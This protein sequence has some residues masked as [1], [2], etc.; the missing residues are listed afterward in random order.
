MLGVFCADLIFFTQVR[1]AGAT[2]GAFY[3]TKHGGGTVDSIPFVGVDRSVNPDWGLYYNEALQAGQYP[4]GE[5]THCHEPHASFGTTEPEPSSGNDAGPDIYLLMKDY[6]STDQTNR[7]YAELCWYCHESINFDPFLF[8]GTGFWKFYQGKSIYKASSHFTSSDLVWPGTT[9]DPVDVFPR[10]DRDG[11]PDGNKGSCLNCHTP[12]GILESSGNEF[13][14]D[15]VPTSPTNLHLA[16]N[17]ASVSTDNLIPRQLIAWEEALCENCHDASGPAG[18]D[19]QTLINLRSSGVG[20]GHPVDSTGLAGRHSVY[21][22]LPV[23]DK[24]VECYDCHNPHAVKAPTGVLGDGEAGRIQGMRYIDIDGNVQDPALGVRQPYIFEICLKCHGNSW[25]CNMPYKARGASD[26]TAGCTAIAT[27]KHRG[28]TSGSGVNDQRGH[29]NKRVEFDTT[30]IM[31]AA[32]GADNTKVNSAYHPVASPGRNTSIQ[33]CNQ[34][35][36]AFG[37]T[38]ANQATADMELGNLTINCTDCHN[39]SVAGGSTIRGPITESSLRSTDKNSVYVGSG[40]VGPHGSTFERLFRTD[41][42]TTVS[43][44]SCTGFG[45]W[46]GGGWG[47]G[48]GGSVADRL[49]FRCHHDAAFTESDY[50][51]QGELWTNFWASGGWGG[52]GGW[53]QSLHHYH[54]SQGTSDGVAITCHECHNNVHSNVEANNTQFYSGGGCCTGWPA[55]DNTH[56]LNFGPTVTPDNYAKPAWYFAGGF[57]SVFRCNMRCHNK[58]M[59]SCEYRGLYDGGPGGG[60]WC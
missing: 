39:N 26:G 48:G 41:Y 10:Q 4:P 45:G 46:G 27:L 17:N 13:D 34:L 11:L 9:G 21:E 20:S 37:L 51:N 36:S 52:G 33:L 15:A 2:G 44:G 53:G 1:K 7:N 57:G 47:G 42:Q 25:D 19:I 38:C 29:S 3:N 50:L 5:C 14:T 58:T 24:H 49:C 8:G 35:S 54:L 60:G 43:T 55:D 22:S 6:G 28:N 56:L 18:T 40:S 32:H 12:H 59:S 16:A 31:G 30:T 23:T